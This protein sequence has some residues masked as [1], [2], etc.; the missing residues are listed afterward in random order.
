MSAALPA[1]APAPGPTATSARPALWPSGPIVWYRPSIRR[2]VWRLW[3]FAALWVALGAACLGALRVMRVDFGSAWL[4]L[5]ALGI[6]LVTAG[7]WQLFAGLSRA[8]RVERVLSVHDEGLRWQDGPSITQVAWSDLDE[9]ALAPKTATTAAAISIRAAHTQLEVPA[10]LEGIAAR[11]LAA[12]LMDM[13]KKALLGL[14]VR[15]TPLPDRA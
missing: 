5:Y 8:V 10:E 4:P 9:V 15:L 1:P 7:P 11:D 3:A 2:L 6:G 14:P 12:M 13:R